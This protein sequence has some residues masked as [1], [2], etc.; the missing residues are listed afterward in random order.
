MILQNL[1]LN[2]FENFVEIQYKYD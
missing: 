2:V 1:A